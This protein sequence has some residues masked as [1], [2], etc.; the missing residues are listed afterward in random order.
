MG[1]GRVGFNSHGVFVLSNHLK[2][3]FGIKHATQLCDRRYAGCSGVRT[4]HARK[5]HANVLLLN[6]VPEAAL[7][8]IF[9]I[10]VI[11]EP[12]VLRSWD[13]SGSAVSEDS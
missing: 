5:S 12:A 9:C 3:Y 8:V 7:S 1:F 10:R 6:A 11:R 2:R 4:S 13:L